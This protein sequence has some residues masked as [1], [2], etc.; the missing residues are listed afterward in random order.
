MPLRKP[1]GKYALNPT[2]D[3]PTKPKVL[4]V[5]DEPKICAAL[6]GALV[7]DGF[8]VVFVES[9][10]EAINAFRDGTFDI[11]LM[12]LQMPGRSGWETYAQLAWSRPLL[13]VIIITAL[14]DQY[15]EA[16]A[17]GVG[18][19]LEKPLDIPLLRETMCRLLA[20]SIEEGLARIA[21]KTPSLVP[22]PCGTFWQR[23]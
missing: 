12:D 1:P 23:H 21:G 16:K 9:G 17:T 11:V 4:V 5:D 18:A 2:D 3:Q 6:A 15:A 10:H 7:S 22:K 13:P 20:E 19:V 14:P 8:E